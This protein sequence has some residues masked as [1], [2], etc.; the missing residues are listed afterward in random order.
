MK[1]IVFFLCLTSLLCL[2]ACTIQ[3]PT[4]GGL[5]ESTAQEQNQDTTAKTDTSDQPADSK[6]PTDTEPDTDT[7]TDMDTTEAQTTY[8][9]LHFPETDP[10]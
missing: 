3:P 10:E 5:G 6:K 9:P 1:K 8:G 7:D 2:S 4:P